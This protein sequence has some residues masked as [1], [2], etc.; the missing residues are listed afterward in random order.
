MHIVDTH[1]H[2]GINW[3][4]P[5]EM[6]LHQMNMN[7]VQSAVLIQHGG[8]Y[9]NQYLL[10]CVQRFPGRFAAVVGVDPTAVNASATLEGVAKEDG[11]VGLRLRPTDRS[12]GPDPLAIWRKAGELGLPI[13]CFA[14]NADHTAS[15]EFRAL[16]ADL[17]GCQIV[18]E[19]LAGVYQSHSPQSATPP[20]TAYRTALTLA[21][22]PNTYIKFCGL[23]EFCIRPPRLQPHF[24]FADV[25][26]LVEMAYEAFGPRRMMWGSDYPP[27]SGREGYRNALQGMV[28]HPAFTSPE[29]REWAFGK[30]A[31]E[32]WKLDRL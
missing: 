17:S 32:V 25:P 13:S 9:D 30:T 20:F 28:E 24:G 22:Y 14:I 6:L 8:N 3:F 1:C 26:P 21:T 18:L 5:V 19:H 12:P 23:G 16:V 10:E 27:V 4:E 7:G 11:V 29:D 2:A 31:Q 15:A